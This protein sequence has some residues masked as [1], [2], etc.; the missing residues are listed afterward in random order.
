MNSLAKRIA[1]SSINTLFS[2]LVVTG[3]WL[4]SLWALDVTPYIGK[5]PIDVFNFLFNSVNASSNR[6]LVFLAL[7]QT[8]LDALIGFS[9]G[10]VFA[11]LV[12]VLFTLSRGIEQALMPLAMLLR[13]VPLIAMA[14]IIILIFGRAEL[15]VSVMGAIVVLF[16]ALVNIVF[17]LRSVSP[18][19]YDLAKVY[20]AG[21]ITILRTVAFPSS[22][23]SFFA[24]LKISVPGAI[25]GAL[26][27]EWL[28]TGSGIGYGIVSAV[29]RAK[30]NE[31]WAYV[32]VITVVSILL[33]NLV[34][35]LEEMVLKRYGYR[36]SSV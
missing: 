28:A 31:V 30:A 22:L 6:D 11:T 35:L 20:G 8:M 15:T 10:M 2:L 18:A 14:P 19:M 3:L 7:G 17:G 1:K 21:R 26:L 34:A 16:P 25:T 4:F 32:V 5:S 23:P 29:G 12:S 27:V 9:F 36:T 33:Y 13:S 24:A